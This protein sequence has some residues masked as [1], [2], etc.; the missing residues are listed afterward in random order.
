M[1]G[2]VNPKRRRAGGNL[3]YARREG[4]FMNFRRVI[5][6]VVAA[7]FVASSAMA[8]GFRIPETGSKAMGMGFAFTAQA[9]DPSAIYFNPAG[10][11]QLTGTNMMTGLTAI[12]LNGQTFTGSTA[13]NAAVEETQEDLNFF[14]P[15]MY[16]T[17]R[18]TTTNWAYGIGVYTPF[19][20]GQEYGDKNTSAFRNLTTK[21]DLQTVC[22]NPTIAYKLDDS[23]SLGFGIDYLY[24]KAKLAKTPVSAAAGD[25]TATGNNNMYK[26][27][28]DGTGD[29]WGYNAGLLIKASENLKVG[30]NYRSKFDL[31][32]NDGEVKISDIS[33]AS[34]TALGGASV[35]TFFGGTTYATKGNTALYLPATFAAGVSYNATPKLTVNFDAD[36]TFWSSYKSLVITIKD[37]VGSLL[38][39]TS[40]SSK[41]WKDVVAL[42]FGGEYKAN[43][44]LALRAGYTFDPTPVPADTLSAE[45]P[46]SDRN[47]F[48]FGAGYKVGAITIDG[49]YMYITKKTRTIAQSAY[50]SA[51]P[52]D[53]P[54]INGTWKGDAHLVSFDLGYKF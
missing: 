30:F 42:R 17:R 19:G 12:Q 40:A 52:T 7:I 36:A 1:T 47:C 11:T 25:N 50:S 37:P 21:I 44:A 38:P 9:D 39:A 18:S 13:I 2:R 10:L 41:K 45:L 48:N 26:L 53:S 27:Q 28:L 32:F 16:L 4:G 35:S 22:V 33:T 5:F 49:S 46:D 29:A 34:R 54:G 43:E 31:E 8:A 51:Y 3:K 20:L 24:G 14:I 23:I 15:N 6:L